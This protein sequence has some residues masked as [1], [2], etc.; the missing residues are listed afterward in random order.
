MANI[1]LVDFD[2]SENKK[3][4]KRFIELQWKIYKDDPAWV[5]PLQLTVIDNIDT[6]KN[7][8]F[9]HAEIRLWNAY[10]GEEHV[11]RIAAVVDQ[12][13]NEIHEEKIGFW[14]FFE[15]VNNSSVAQ[16]LF[17]AAE[18]WVKQR[19]MKAIRGP[20]NPSTNHECGLLVDGFKTQPYVMMTH[21]PKY[22]QALVEE[23]GYTKAKDL[24]AFEIPRPEEL[25]GKIARVAEGVMKRGGF[26]IR[27]IN[28]KNFQEDVQ[29]ILDIYNSAWEKNWGFV[30][31]DEAEFRHMAKSMK[32]VLWPEL[33][34]IAFHGEE[35]IGFSL[36]LPD[37]N[38]VLRDI[39]NGKLLP[40]GIFKLIRGLNPKNRKIDR[41]RVI[42]LGVKEKY[43]A[44][45][46]GSVF[47]YETYRRSG[48]LGIKG[49]EASWI[50]EDNKQMLSAIAAFSPAPPHKT[51]RIYDKSF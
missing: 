29:L 46:V 10:I 6:K 51:Y 9:K 27:P 3:E 37:I 43:R 24:L 30:P 25:T 26:T 38:Q 17:E 1:R 13:H 47:Y 36:G 19:G 21:N 34:L 14:G 20:M 49:G 2:P 11:G 22:Y 39:P 16:A 8:F 48:E 41:C 7:P 42:T 45:G 33:C 15:A 23:R 5:P 31:M 4:R 12:R 32:D 40:W 50:L 35:P 44:T 28:M 18:S